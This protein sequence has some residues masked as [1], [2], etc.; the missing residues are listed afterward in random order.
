MTIKE[1]IERID[2]MLNSYSI[3]EMTEE[4]KQ[5]IQE[6]INNALNDVEVNFSDDEINEM[7]PLRPTD[8]TNSTVDFNTAT[9]Q[10]RLGAKMMRDKIV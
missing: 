2:I 9:L 7:L 4:A 5:S 1:R 8:G 6:Q 3:G 10:A